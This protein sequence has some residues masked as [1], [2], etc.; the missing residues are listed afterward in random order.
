MSDHQ[1]LPS[2][3]FGREQDPRTTDSPHNSIIRGK[4]AI[5]QSCEPAE[6]WLIQH[7]ITRPEADRL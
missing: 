7:Y 3:A 6:S 4:G 1:S 2:H 5:A